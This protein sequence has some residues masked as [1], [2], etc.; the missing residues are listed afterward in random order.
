M[1]IIKQHRFK[2]IALLICFF[3]GLTAN[4]V[5]A[6]NTVATDDT[7]TDEKVEELTFTDF[8]KATYSLIRKDSSSTIYLEIKNVDLKT[9]ANSKREYIAFLTNGDEKAPIQYGTSGYLE[10]GSLSTKAYCYLTSEKTDVSVHAG[11]K[12]ALAG[13]I[14]L[15]IVEW[16]YAD[17][18]EGTTTREHYKTVVDRVK[19]K[20][21]SQLA[22]TQRI[23]SYFSSGNTSIIN[24]ENYQL[25]DDVQYHVKIGRV[26]DNDLL[27]SIKNSEANCLEDL[28]NYAKGASAVYETNL[29]KQ[30]TEG[31]TKN[32][33]I[34]DDAYYYAYI[35]LDTENG[36]YYP[37]EDIMLYQGLVSSA[38]NIYSLIN[39]LDA[40][41]VWNLKEETPQTN[42]NITINQTTNTTNTTNNQPT[43][44]TGN[45]DNTK[46]PGTIP[47]TGSMPF[48]TICILAIILGVGGVAYY[49]NR[50]Y[51]GL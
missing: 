50:K 25:G 44:V 46:A 3:I 20:R 48:T 41:F 47:Q 51:Q 42:N 27:R 39:Y 16:N 26:T 2:I 11:S 45:L 7:T 31:I 1:K 43:S 33:T 38:S 9:D 32:F 6:T 14:Y 21:P 15:T 4:S 35:S 29:S 23:H 12:L 40:D 22:L 5:F 37:I 34:I 19:I 36:T 10:L 30:Q 49:H 24:F 18:P 17:A 8:S 13:D 28:L